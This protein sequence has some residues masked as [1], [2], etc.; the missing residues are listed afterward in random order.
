MHSVGIIKI[1]STIRSG[2]IKCGEYPDYL[3]TISLTV[4]LPCN[5]CCC[6]LSTE[7]FCIIL[8]VGWHQM[9]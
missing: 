6:P 4:A 1:H 7:N 3:K 5:D 9:T 2:C 8:P